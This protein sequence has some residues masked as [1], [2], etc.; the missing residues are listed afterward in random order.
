MRGRTALLSGV[1]AVVLLAQGCRALHEASIK[2]RLTQ[3]RFFGR[4]VKMPLKDIDTFLSNR[5]QDAVRTWC[6]LCLVSAQTVGD[7][8]HLYCLSSHEEEGCVVARSTPSGG[9]RFE[10]APVGAQA[11]AQVVRALW[12]VVDLPGAADSEQQN[13][14]QE[15]A[16]IASE[17]EEHF[18]PRW[19]FILGAKTGA[20]VS[21]DQPSFTFGGQAGVRYWGSLFVV[22]GAVLEVES[23]VQSGRTLV[24]LGAQGRVE[25]TLWSDE[26]ARFA[27]LPRITFLMS[28]GPLVGFGNNPGL[29][30]R[31]VLGLHLI[32]LGRFLTPFFFELGFQALEVDEKSSTGLR[33]AVGLGF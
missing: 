27:N 2:Q 13:S 12:N 30:G 24:N 22:P 15:I 5:R 19:S 33:I 20:V 32:H 11:S 4:E 16:A 7:G 18:T 8:S 25:L 3:M 6:E 10:Q 1:C 29:G 17:E 21:Y 14:E 9:T 26:N 31:A 23:L 28:G